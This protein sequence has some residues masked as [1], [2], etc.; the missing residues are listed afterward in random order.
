MQAN[1]QRIRAIDLVPA[2]RRVYVQD[3]AG[4]RRLFETLGEG[5]P[6]KAPR[7]EAAAEFAA[8]SV[9][10]FKRDFPILA[11][12]SWPAF[13]REWRLLESWR[14]L[15]EPFV[16]PKDARLAVGIRSR[17]HFNEGFHRR[18][19]IFP[20]EVPEAATPPPPGRRRVR[21]TRRVTASGPNGNVF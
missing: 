13:R 8:R 2:K 19:G 6:A 15:A 9:T 14:L 1:G 12:C 10:R 4:F 17:G 7:Q 5:G 21:K 16:A 3:D 18:F 20:S 11:G